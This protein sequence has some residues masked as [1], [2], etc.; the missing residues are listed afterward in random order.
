MQKHQ[1]LLLLILPLSADFVLY[2][3]SFTSAQ[4]ALLLLPTW[5]PR[6]YFQAPFFWM[7]LI[8]LKIFIPS[9]F[10][11]F[12]ILSFCCFQM[13][14]LIGPLLQNCAT[15][16]LFISERKVLDCESHETIIDLFHCHYISSQKEQVFNGSITIVNLL[17]ILFFLSRKISH[18]Y[19]NPFCCKISGF[20][21]SSFTTQNYKNCIKQ[22]NITFHG[23]VES[24][25][26]DSKENVLKKNQL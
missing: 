9:M 8:V 20:L 15:S 10:L 26:I 23:N 24:R 18:L 4:S 7:L 13:N 2:F 1:L 11:M 6:F 19:A 12:L 16:M 14:H 25:L 17:M 5:L 21:I 3:Q 22:C